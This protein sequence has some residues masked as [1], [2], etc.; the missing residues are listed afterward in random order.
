M[1]DFAQHA[2]SSTAALLTALRRHSVQLQLL[3]G[4][5]HDKM[6][7]QSASAYSLSSKLVSVQKIDPSG[8]WHRQTAQLQ[9]SD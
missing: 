3:R 6:P 1:R 9:S 2:M 7:M 5:N 8:R 4:C